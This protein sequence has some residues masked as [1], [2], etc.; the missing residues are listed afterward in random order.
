MSSM[1][2]RVHPV[3]ESPPSPVYGQTSNAL[4]VNDVASEAKIFDQESFKDHL[5]LLSL[6]KVNHEGDETSLAPIIAARALN[7]P[8]DMPSGSLTKLPKVQQYGL[9]AGLAPEM[10]FQKDEEVNPHNDPRV[11]FNVTSPSSTFICGSQGSGKS[12]SLS[13]ILENC[14]IPSKAGNLKNPLTGLVFH[15]DLFISDSTGSPCEA[16]FLSSSPEVK[17]RVLCSP[18]NIQTMRY[19]YSRFKNVTVEPL[20]IDET[21]LNTQR[22]LNLMAVSQSDTG[23]PLYMHTLLRILRELRIEQQETGTQFKYQEFKSRLLDANL[24]NAQCEPLKQR[25]DTLE[26]FMPKPQ[27]GFFSGGQ[28]RKQNVT[29]R[30][31][32]TWDP[33][34][35]RL[36]IIDLSCPCISPDTACCL[37]DICLSIFLEQDQSVG[38]VVALDEAHK[39]MN[40]SAEASAFTKAL[41]AVV[42]LQRHL[43]VRIIISTQEPTISTDLLNLCSVT[44]VHRFTSPEWFRILHHHLAGASDNCFAAKSGALLEDE[45]EEEEAE[46]LF[47]KIV[48]LTVGEALLFAPSAIVGTR[49]AKDGDVTVHRLG[50]RHL[51]VKVRARLT[52]DGGKCVLSI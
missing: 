4:D 21:D 10:G 5:D 49:V 34:A 48:R 12:H 46:S 36:T 51:S 28:K 42:R 31:G 11:L 41:L 32:S 44:I 22:M 33:V 43:G 39:Y 16:A 8:S 9:L 27:A 37:F 25:L 15:Y 29:A 38:R 47:T 2:E 1:N 24:T 18:T 52:D 23:M 19:T 45:N 20:Q 26:S 40:S 17:V 6:A 30:R 50:V 14:L 7:L 35:G 13:C 3:A